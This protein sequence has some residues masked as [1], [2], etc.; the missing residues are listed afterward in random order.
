MQQQLFSC[1]KGLV[2]LPR[3][4][5]CYSICPRAPSLSCSLPIPPPFAPLFF[6]S[7]FP[8]QI[9][10]FTCGVS[11]LLLTSPSEAHRSLILSQAETIGNEVACK[12]VGITAAGACT[13]LRRWGEGWAMDCDESAL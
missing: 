12:F 3:V 4:V 1:H 8:P 13:A 5:L 7:S 11:D 6:L 10:G 2:H 9:H